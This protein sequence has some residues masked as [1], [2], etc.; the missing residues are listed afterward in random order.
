MKKIFNYERGITLVV[1]VLTIIILLILAGITISSL[2]NINLFKR[3][4]EAKNTMKNADLEQGLILNKYEDALKENY[5]E[6]DNNK[7]VKLVSEIKIEQENVILKV[8]EILDLS[9]IISP[10]DADNK[11]LDW[12]SS[13]SNVVSVEKNGK[14][15]AISGG[16]ATI[17]AKAKDGSNVY[18]TCE[19]VVDEEL[20][21]FDYRSGGLKYE[22][23]KI[24]SGYHAPVI[25]NTYV[26]GPCSWA[27][28]RMESMEDKANI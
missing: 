16:N 9:V 5:I 15:T 25:T 19:V 17:T 13:N 23:E 11:E 6:K 4:K 3:A 8:G 27:G 28:C 18:G 22:L 2:T 12:T 24:D 7:Q 26:T 1:L 21:L 14:V 20:V 10:N